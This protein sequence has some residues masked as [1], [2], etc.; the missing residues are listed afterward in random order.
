MSMSFR[1]YIASEEENL[2]E[3]F[4]LFKGW[5][6]KES[7]P[8]SQPK[9]QFE[10]STPAQERGM[11]WS[12]IENKPQP[13]MREK[14]SWLRSDPTIA[15]TKE[16]EELESAVHR[17]NTGP[18]KP[19]R[20]SATQID[21]MATM[22]NQ[23]GASKAQANVD[24]RIN[25]FLK[26]KIKEVMLN[27]GF[28]PTDKATDKSNV[29]QISDEVM[30]A[31]L[32]LMGVGEMQWSLEERIVKAINDMAYIQGKEQFRPHDD[33]DFGATSR[34]PKKQDAQEELTQK[35]L[36]MRARGQTIDEIGIELGLSPSSIV[37]LLRKY[38]Q[39]SND[40]ND[41]D[42][43]QLPKGTR[44]TP[45]TPVAPVEEP[46]QRSLFDMPPE[47]DPQPPAVKPVRTRRKKGEDPAQKT[48]F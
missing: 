3:I 22:F 16:F 24:A 13:N 4:G 2:H 1:N 15:K 5:G 45:S 48:L 23:R 28:V 38:N 20:P 18:V 9:A 8:P 33:F 46:A 34:L 43:V 27:R 32:P 30:K 21:L 25:F 14:M 31:W 29:L 41:P 10:P 35:V 11:M 40:P 39:K 12:Q 36:A 19:D 47:V 42:V 17:V 6:K 26:N 37:T 7:P 44:T